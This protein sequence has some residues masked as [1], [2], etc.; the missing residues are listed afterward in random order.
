MPDSDNLV[1]RVEEAKRRGEMLL[2]RREEEGN[3][4]GNPSTTDGRL[5]RAIRE[6]DA[7]AR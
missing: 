7:L 2:R 6:A 4:Y 1:I 5:T 3:K